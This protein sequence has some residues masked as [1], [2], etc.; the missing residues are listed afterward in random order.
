MLK[1]IYCHHIRCE[2]C[3]F[4]TKQSARMNQHLE[5]YHVRS[6]CPLCPNAAFN[7]KIPL[8]AHLKEAHGVN[9]RYDD[10]TL[11]HNYSEKDTNFH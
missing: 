4:V 6:P 8:G 1:R 7:G 10:F 5:N 9:A 2:G 3:A 11:K